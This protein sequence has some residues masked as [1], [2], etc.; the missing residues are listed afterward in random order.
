MTNRLAQLI[1]RLE[2]DEG[3]FI[4]LFL[5]FFPLTVYEAHLAELA[6]RPLASRHVI[7]WTKGV[8]LLWIGLLMRMTTQP[9]PNYEWHWR[10]PTDFLVA[11]QNSLKLLMMEV[12]FK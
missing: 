1:S 12:R 6:T 11:S 7:R 3:P 9:L 2:E 4:G 8:F 10:W 5:R